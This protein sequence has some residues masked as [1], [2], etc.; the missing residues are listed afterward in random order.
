MQFKNYGPIATQQNW[1]CTCN[2]QWPDFNIQQY[3]CQTDAP[4]ITIPAS[5]NFSYTSPGSI[6]A[7]QQ[8]AWQFCNSVNNIYGNQYQTWLTTQ[9][10]TGTQVQQLQAQ[11]CQC[12]QSWP[13]LFNQSWWLNDYGQSFFVVSCPAPT[14]VTPVKP[15]IPVI[16]VQTSSNTCSKLG[17]QYGFPQGTGCCCLNNA[18]H[19]YGNSSDFTCSAA[20][21]QCAPANQCSYLG[22]PWGF[23]NG[24]FVG[25][26]INTKWVAAA[27]GCCCAKPNHVA[28]TGNI[29]DF[30]CSATVTACW[31]SMILLTNPNSVLFNENNQRAI[32]NKI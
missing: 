28:G 14:P 3:P 20:L 32:W 29:L 31:S 23:G 13:T 30:T 5:L 24:Q 8:Q 4:P 11:Y 25:T 22:N 18:K 12:Y 7:D 27:T 9:V 15:V 26:G 10:W 16:P 1:Q 19:K 6:T 17:S 2:N 21:I